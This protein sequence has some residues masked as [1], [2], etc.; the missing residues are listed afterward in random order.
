MI[1]LNLSD[2]KK[3]PNQVS[4]FRI[5]LILPLIYFFKEPL[6]NSW[7]LITTFILFS[8]L[9]NLDG[10]LARRLNQ[11]TELGKVIDPLVDKIFIIIAAYFA[12]IN[13]LVP[14]WYMLS[15][16][17]RDIIIMMA[18]LVFIKKK[19]SVPP[20]DFI[21]KMTVG[22]IGIVFIYGLLGFNKLNLVYK[23]ILY[24]ST[25]LIILSLVNYGL[26]NLKRKT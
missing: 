10:F 18:G 14:D 2:L 21:G 9:D 5:I 22:S 20:S 26:K 23:F 7:L 19:T 17:S 1:R 11:I 15:V 4:L 3:I 6:E 25:F 13:N 16:I 12:F 8:I 24:I